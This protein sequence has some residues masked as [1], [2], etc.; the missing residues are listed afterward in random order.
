MKNIYQKNIGEYV[1]YTH[2]Y[3]RFNSFN[4]FTYCN[5]Y[6]ILDINCYTIPIIKV[7]IKIIDDHDTMRW[8]NIK[9]FDD[10]NTIRELKL[11][12]II[13]EKPI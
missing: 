12:N 7:L 2:K 8:I 9:Y 3:S 11:K 4:S 13:Q 6:K 1:I 5:E 10:I